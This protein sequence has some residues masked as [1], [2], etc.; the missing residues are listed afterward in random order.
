MPFY[1]RINPE[2]VDGKR[3]LER[4]IALRGQLAREIP[5]RNL[6]DSLLLAT[7]N[8]REFDSPAYGTRLPES[9]YYIAEIISHFDLVAIQE[10]RKDLAAIDKVLGILGGYWKY[11]VTDVTKGSKGNKERLAYL[12]DSR[13]VR[14]G[15][16]AGELVL[17]P[18]KSKDKDGKNIYLPATQISRTP[19][20]SGFKTGWTKFVLVTVHILYGESSANDPERVKE[21]EQIAKF[22]NERSGDQSAWSRNFILLGDF[23]IFKTGDKTMRALTDNGFEIPEELLKNPS[24]AIETRHFDQIAF[25]VRKDRF[26]DV[27]SQAGVFQFFRTVF[28]PRDEEVYAEKMGKGYIV[29]SKGKRR[30]AN[31]KTNYYKTYWRTHQ[32]SDHLP[33]WVEIKIDYSDEYLERKLKQAS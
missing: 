25:R 16:L 4:L 18:T 29:D 22:L 27:T 26:A 7:W 32:M 11:L 21:I 31:K 8:I 28:R 9:L 12:Y 33:M 2:T 17:P 5:L 1:Q 6:E 23:N 19:F 14:M 10:V 15:G 3:T 20:I 24:N 13:K 30:D